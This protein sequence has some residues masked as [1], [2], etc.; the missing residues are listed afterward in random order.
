MSFDEIVVILEQ[1]TL[2]LRVDLVDVE[3]LHSKM[4]T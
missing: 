3:E 4:F 2:P 1:L